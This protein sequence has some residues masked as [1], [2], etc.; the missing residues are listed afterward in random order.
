MGSKVTDEQLHS[1]FIHVTCFEKD[2]EA[3][4]RWFKQQRGK[5]LGKWTAVVFHSP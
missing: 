5:V 2:V 4:G 3:G 1:G